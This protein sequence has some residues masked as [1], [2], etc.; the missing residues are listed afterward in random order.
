MVGLMVAKEEENDLVMTQKTPQPFQEGL[1][2]YVPNIA[3]KCEIRGCC[4][5]IKS[6]VRWM[7]LKMQIRDYLDQDHSVRV[8]MQG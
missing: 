1:V 5:E 3:K 8:A 4:R 7:C 6:R 2:T